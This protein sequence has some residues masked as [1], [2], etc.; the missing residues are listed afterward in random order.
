GTTEQDGTTLEKISLAP[1]IKVEPNP[2]AAMKVK[3]V[4]GSGELLFDNKAGRLLESTMQQ[5][6]VSEVNAMGLTLNQTAV[7]IT[8]IRLVKKTKEEAEAIAIGTIVLSPAEVEKE[9]SSEV[10]E[11]L[12]GVVAEFERTRTITRE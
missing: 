1:T 12:A 3:S 7:Q 9:A 5:T 10:V 8:T 2:Q 4:K 6:T 11:T